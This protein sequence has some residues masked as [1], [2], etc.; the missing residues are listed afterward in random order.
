MSITTIHEGDKITF[1]PDFRQDDP[2]GWAG[3]ATVGDVYEVVELD[4]EDER[5]PL[6][7]N[8]GVI[9]G[10]FHP[11]QVTVVSSVSEG[12]TL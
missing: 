4:L 6:K 10:W 3:Y 9:I 5:T 1:N 7:I 2:R 11:R 8:L 12:W